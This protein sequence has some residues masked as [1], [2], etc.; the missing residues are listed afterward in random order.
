M[1]MGITWDVW[2][3]YLLESYSSTLSLKQSSLLEQ[4]AELS[5]LRDHVTY[6]LVFKIVTETP[7]D[8]K[9]SHLFG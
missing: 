2:L 1:A 8:L 4:D 7:S 3:C 5:R 9:V 6:W